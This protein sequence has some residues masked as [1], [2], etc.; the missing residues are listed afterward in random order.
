[1]ELGDK[2]KVMSSGDEPFYWHL[3]E[4]VNEPKLIEVEVCS[5]SLWDHP[6]YGPLVWVMEKGGYEQWVRL[7]DLKAF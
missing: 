7:I 5:T 2:F 1:M 6:V 3:A 4:N